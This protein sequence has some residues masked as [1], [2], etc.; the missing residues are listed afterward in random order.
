MLMTK[1]YKQ[2]FGRTLAAA[3]FLSLAACGTSRTMV[4]EAPS[5]DDTYQGLQI[6]E[7]ESLVQVPADARSEIK[8]YLGEEIMYTTLTAISSSMTLR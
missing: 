6:V 2:R 5:T 4:L 1:V 7:G 3:M 8:K